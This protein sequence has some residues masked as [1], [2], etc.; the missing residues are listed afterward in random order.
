MLECSTSKHR[1]FVIPLS[2]FSL[3]YGLG[4]TVQLNCF[5]GPYSYIM[6]HYY[7]GQPMYFSERE[8]I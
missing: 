7:H 4:M 5:H 2:L 3:I 1:P 8:V 6:D